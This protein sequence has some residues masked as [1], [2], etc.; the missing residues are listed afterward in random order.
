[1]DRRADL[2]AP[3]TRTQAWSIIAL[4][5]TLSLEHVAVDS[6]TERILY[7]LHLE[8]EHSIPEPFPENADFLTL[9]GVSG[10]SWV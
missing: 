2:H 8:L 7:H 10:R 4:K 9:W 3:A 6:D 5:G 1:M